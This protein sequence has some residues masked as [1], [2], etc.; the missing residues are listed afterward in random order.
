[1]PN[2]SGRA[3]MLASM[4]DGLAQLLAWGHLICSLYRA[5]TPTA[6]IRT[7]HGARP[8]TC[9]RATG[10][11]EFARE[12]GIPPGSSRLPKDTSGRQVHVATFLTLRWPRTD[13]AG[14][15]RRE[16][17]SFSRLRLALTPSPVP[18]RLRSR[19]SSRL[20]IRERCCNTH[21]VRRRPAMKL[22]NSCSVSGP[23]SC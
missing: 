1:L 16:R 11:F 4:E 2:G 18:S 21:R 10:A 15:G 22:V 7:H 17:R 6:R 19:L 23:C 12:H 9:R 14:D 8:G 5:P 20:A 13:E 3:Q